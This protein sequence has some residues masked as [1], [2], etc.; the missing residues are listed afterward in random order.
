M[1]KAAI[2]FVLFLLFFLSGEVR[3]QEF[4]RKLQVTLAP[5]NLFDPVTGVLQV[6]IQKNFQGGLA[7]SLDHGVRMNPYGLF[8]RGD[9][10]LFFR[11]GAEREDYRYSKTRMEVKRYFGPSYRRPFSKFLPYLSLEAL[12]FP[13]KYRKEDDWIFREGESFLYEHSQ[14]RRNVWVAS[15]K[16]GKEARYGR[17]MFD[18]FVGLGMRN[19]SIR[20]Q[21]FG[22]VATVFEGR[23]MPL[24]KK[25]WKEGVSTLPHLSLGF[26]IG[27]ILRE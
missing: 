1:A 13:Q 23:G 10:P 19:V 27:Y 9:L 11:L 17:M 20:H 3:S 4:D 5:L 18:Q 2:P 7:L 8:S 22:E 16:I 24:G 14:V 12:Y 25:D 15:L 21:T 26:K 6:G